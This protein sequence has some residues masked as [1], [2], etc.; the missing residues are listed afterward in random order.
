MP[1]FRGGGSGLGPGPAPGPPSG[2]AAEQGCGEAGPLP[3][4]P[5]LREVRV[6]EWM[7]GLVG[8][9]T[10]KELAE[11]AW[12]YIC[13]FKVRSNFAFD[14]DF[15]TGQKRFQNLFSLCI[16][17]PMLS[18]QSSI[19][20]FPF[21][22]MMVQGRVRLDEILKQVNGQWVPLGMQSG[23]D[24]KVNSNNP[25]THNIRNLGLKEEACLLI[26]PWS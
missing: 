15:L 8:R 1:P 21:Q 14:F 10:E 12:N 3:L 18:V 26:K 2:R 7:D 22:I 20:F 17:Q 11:N 25:S 5:N 13:C 23:D 24:F 19:L 6:D 9:W 4:W 16:T